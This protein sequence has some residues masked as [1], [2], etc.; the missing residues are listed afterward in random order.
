MSLKHRKVINVADDPAAAEKLRPSDWGSPSTNYDTA[1]THVFDGGTDGA[2]AMRDTEAVDGFSWLLPETGVLVRDDD[3]FP[4]FRALEAGDIPALPYA[5]ADLTGLVVDGDIVSLAWSKLTGTPTSLAG[6]GIAD[7]I[8]VT[9]GTYADP[10]WITSLAGAKVTGTVALATLAAAATVLATPRAINGVAFDGSA[11]ITVT[12]AAGTLAGTTLNAT[13]VTSSLTSVGTLSGLTVAAPTSVGTESCFYLKNS[14]NTPLMLV[15][16]DGRVAFGISDPAIMNEEFEI[17]RE[18]I[19]ATGNSYGLRTLITLNPPTNALQWAAGLSEMVIPSGNSSNF[20]GLVR[21]SYNYLRH[22]GSGTVAE[23]ASTYTIYRGHNA[24]VMTI[25]YSFTD[26]VQL[27]DTASIGTYYHFRASPIVKNATNTVVTEY[28]LYIGDI[29]APAAVGRYAIW[30]Q[31]STNK[32]HFAGPVDF[33]NG[34]TAN[35]AAV[36]RADG[37]EALPG[38]ATSAQANKGMFHPATNQLAWST[39]GT[40]KMRLSASGAFG[41]GT[42]TPLAKVSINGGLH[43]GGDSDPGDDNCVI[44]GTLTIGSALLSFGANDSAG[45]GFRLVRVPNA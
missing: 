1:P 43:V 8:V 16:N 11:A 21:A 26:S 12:A 42:K 27:N 36:F 9:S 35:G 23:G 17:R 40:E 2:L 33:D 15:R 13:V 31:G 29:T 30:T 32:V 20:T 7:P 38:Y 24:S 3:A 39:I 28:G 44:D 18:R 45:A 22:E 4:G 25:G 34:V 6:Y 10:A 41:V 5:P 19:E 37:T 14:D